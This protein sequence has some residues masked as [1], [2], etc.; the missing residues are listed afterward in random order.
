M[1]RTLCLT[2]ALILS[3][4]SLPVC[5]HPAHDLSDSTRPPLEADRLLLEFLAGA[6]V[7]TMFT[8]MS[9]AV[10][11][12]TGD[13]DLDDIGVAIVTAIAVGGLGASLGVQGVGASGDQSGS[14]LATALGGLMGTAGMF[15]YIA[16]TSDSDAAYLGFT[17]PIIGAMLGFNVTRSYDDGAHADRA[18]R[19]D[20]AEYQWDQAPGK[21]SFESLHVTKANGAKAAFLRTAFD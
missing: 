10:I 5:A 17:F 11:A 4:Y 6:A 21:Q 8:F 1:K 14:Y 15:G 2:L 13:A 20:H 9:A 19:V 7:G 12:E 18:M 3:L 16:A